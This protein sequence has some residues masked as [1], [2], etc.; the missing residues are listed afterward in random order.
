MSI[1]DNDSTFTVRIDDKETGNYL[2]THVIDGNEIDQ[3]I[4]DTEWN[5][6]LTI[7]EIDLDNWN[8]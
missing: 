7:E 8:W 5:D 1:F 4:I 2:T 3:A 6:I